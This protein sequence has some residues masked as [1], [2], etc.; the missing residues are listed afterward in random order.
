MY[1][2]ILAVFAVFLSLPAYAAQTKNTMKMVSYFPVPYV[3]YDTVSANNAMDIGILNQCEMDINKGSTNLGGSACSLYL[4]GNATGADLNRGLLNVAAGKLDL[5]SDVTN[6]RIVSKKVQV[7]TSMTPENGW[8]DIG[9]PSGKND[10]Y[11]ALYI[12]SLKNTGNSFRVTSKE[13]GAKVNSFHMFNEI[14]NDFPGCAGTVTWQELELAANVNNNETYTDVY[15]VCNGTGEVTP[16]QDC[17]APNGN[18]YTESCPDGQEGEIVFTWQGEPVC[19]YKETNN[20][21]EVCQPT[22]GQSYTEHCPEGQS[23]NITYTWNQ[24]TCKYDKTQDTCVNACVWQATS[25]VEKTFTP[26]DDDTCYDTRPY[27]AKYFDEASLEQQKAFGR[28]CV[29]WRMTPGYSGQVPTWKI[30]QYVGVACPG[31]ANAGIGSCQGSN[32]Y[33][34]CQ[35]MGGEFSVNWDH[36]VYKNP[37]QYL[38][39]DT[40]GINCSMGGSSNTVFGCFLP[41]NKL[42]YICYT[43]RQRSLACKTE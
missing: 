23:G 43:A 4:Y 34:V 27:S 3:A 26:G 6:A 13:D 11:D 40:R 25:W 39:T 19:N 28:D 9:I 10:E 36:F 22:K 35:N 5:N 17:Q 42:A 2:K 15:L 12:S 29:D 30:S 24:A 16:P 32:D 18:R 7:G 20:C 8:L 38:I 37:K 31:A 1:Q 41:D 21:K 14:S 33:D